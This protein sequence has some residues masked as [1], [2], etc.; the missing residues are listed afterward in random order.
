MISTT[1]RSLLKA[2]LNSKSI[3]LIRSRSTN[4]FSTKLPLLKNKEALKL[5]NETRKDSENYW[6]HPLAVFASLTILYGLYW[7]LD[8]Q[9]RGK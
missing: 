4:Q 6:P 2:N 1:L 3:Q 9:Y 8:V 5:K 7:A